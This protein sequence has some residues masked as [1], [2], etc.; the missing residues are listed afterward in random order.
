[1]RR[2]KWLERVGRAL[3]V[4]R[5]IYHARPVSL[6][7]LAA[8]LVSVPVIS[9]V[10]MP[11]TSRWHAAALWSP[12]ASAKGA[13][14]GLLA[15]GVSDVPLTT[16]YPTTNTSKRP[17]SRASASE[18]ASLRFHVDGAGSGAMPPSSARVLVLSSYDSSS[19]SRPQMNAGS[20]RRR[21]HDKALR[22]C[23]CCAQASVP[24]H[25][26]AIGS[27]NRQP[28]LGGVASLP[29]QGSHAGP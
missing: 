27:H 18:R 23:R 16:C 20:L 7:R 9:V 22:R 4:A 2:P 11:K 12:M 19:V 5:G 8:E 26:E 6:A 25:P 14:S 21:G 3:P 10:V 28:W 13:I 24:G 29:Q 17:H 1:V 15:H